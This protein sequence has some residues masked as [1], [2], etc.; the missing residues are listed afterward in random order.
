VERFFGT[1]RQFSARKKRKAYTFSKDL[2]F[3]E[4]STWLL[5]VWY[6][7]GW[8]LGTLRQKVQQDPPRYYYRTPGMAAG[9][10][11]HVWTMQELLCHPLYPAKD[12]LQRSKIRTYR[13]VLERLKGVLPDE[14]PT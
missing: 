2:S 10:T 6:N 11:D 12:A 3:H 7:F 9:L 13:K 14:A 1:Q 4:A 5:V 8:C